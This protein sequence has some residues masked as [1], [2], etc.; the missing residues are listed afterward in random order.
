M[1][2][3]VSREGRSIT[4]QNLRVGGGLSRRAVRPRSRRYAPA[5]SLRAGARQL[6]QVVDEPLRLAALLHA[7]G[8]EADRLDSAT[9]DA[10]ATA[11]TTS[12]ADLTRTGSRY[13]GCS[14]RPT[15][16][17]GGGGVAEPVV[18]HRDGRGQRDVYLPYARF[19]R[20]RKHSNSINFLKRRMSP[21]TSRAASFLASTTPLAN[22]EL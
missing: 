9:V 7:A 22:A 8:P 6:W 12:G 2:S 11:S 17:L 10:L 19:M 21:R 1:I 15:P 4:E 18:R 20:E 3:L 14:P 5:A 13:S 16:D